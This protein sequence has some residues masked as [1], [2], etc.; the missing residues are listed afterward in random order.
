VKLTGHAVDRPPVIW[1]PSG[2]MALGRIS[3]SFS[4]QTKPSA[5]AAGG[6]QYLW[7]ETEISHRG[8]QNL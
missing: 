4:Y 5:I 3:T 1:T 2:C 7:F 6:P 8:D